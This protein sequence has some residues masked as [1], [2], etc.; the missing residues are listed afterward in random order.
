RF[1]TL[2]EPMRLRI[3][4]GLRSGELSVGE[5]VDRTG[6]GQAN[7]SKH[8]QILLSAGL[9]SRRKA[10]TTVYY[11]LTDPTVFQLCDI[12]CGRVEEQVED[13]RRA[14]RRR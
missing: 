2:G 14:L 5:L 3:L 8:L 9:V 4:D 12:V 10:G 6:G 7:I 13:R 1:R 11:R